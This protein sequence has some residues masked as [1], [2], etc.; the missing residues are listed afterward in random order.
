MDLQY[1]GGQTATNEAVELMRTEVF[2]QD[3][4]RPEV[5]NIVILISD[6]VPFPD[7][8]RTPAIENAARAQADGI[9]MFA[10][11]ITF[12]IDEQLL[13]LLS[14]PPRRLD[15]NYFTSPDFEQLD[16]VLERILPTVCP[17]PRPSE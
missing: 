1:Q 2:T 6:G 10:V 8:R 14:S 13:R 17:T 9:Q 15:E 7:S 5:A 4:D 3:G 16:T 11:G 12:L